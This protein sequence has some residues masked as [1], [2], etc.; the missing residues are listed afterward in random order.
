MEKLQQQLD[1]IGKMKQQTDA[2]FARLDG[3]K[4]QMESIEASVTSPDKAV[5]VVAGPGGG[6]KSIKFGEEARKLSPTQLSQS[7][8]TTLQQAVAQAARQQA[9]VVQGAMGE[10]SNV[11]ERVMKTQEQIFGAVPGEDAP[12]PKPAAP[13]PEPQRE[14]PSQA[15]RPAASAWR[16][17]QQQPRREPEPRYDDEEEGFGSVFETEPERPSRPSQ[18]QRNRNRDDEYMR[19]YN[20]EDDW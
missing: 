18:P 9:E 5:T 3:L 8:T 19:F 20:N 15:A 11:L 4:E 10:D 16:P 6:V 12:A 17:A 13:D 14:D 7:A 2:R 1:R